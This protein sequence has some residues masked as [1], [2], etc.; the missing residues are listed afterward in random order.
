MLELPHLPRGLG[1]LVV[2]DESHDR[3]KL[4]WITFTLITLNIT[5]FAAQTRF[6]DQLTLGYAVL[7]M[8]ITEGRDLAP[9]TVDHI[10]GVDGVVML[11]TEGAGAPQIDNRY[12]SVP[13]YSGPNP[14]YLT[15]LTYQFLHGDIFHLAFNLWF[16]FIFGRN[17]ECALGHG[18]FLN[19]YLLCGVIAGL[20]QVGV[21]IKSLTP[22]VGASGAIAGVMGAYLAIHPWNKLKICIGMLVGI[23]AGVVRIPAF[24]FIGVWI[25]GEACHGWMT[26]DQVVGGGVAYFCHIGGFLAGFLYV[27][28]LASFLGLRLRWTSPPSTVV[29]TLADDD[30]VA[31][32]RRSREGVFG[33]SSHR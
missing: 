23:P 13:L 12:V 32:Y 8:E 31:A 3:G 24:L 19:F 26:D 18:R 20:A 30:P 11:V 7:P 4:P 22:I 16:L 1:M 9:S 2:G 6:G 10:P 25:L 27:K 5:V 15:L 21:A 14:I 29:R 17:V 33:A 28:L